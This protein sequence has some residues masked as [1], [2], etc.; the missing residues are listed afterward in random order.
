M[1]N[2]KKNSTTTYNRTPEHQASAGG[3][4]KTERKGET[5]YMCGIQPS[6]FL[7]GFKPK[8]RKDGWKEGTLVCSTRSSYDKNAFERKR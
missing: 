8:D 6:R 4:R 3:R 2:T 1:K 5:G 7:L